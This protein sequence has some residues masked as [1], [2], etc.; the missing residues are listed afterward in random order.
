M[1][2][3]F[4]YDNIYVIESLDSDETQTGSILYNDILKW[5]AIKIGYL[6]CHL[7][8]IDTA[9][10]FFNELEIIKRN[11]QEN[12]TS[13]FLHLE[14]H[15]CTDGLIL[16]SG[17]KINWSELADRFREINIITKNNLFVSLA[18]CYG[19]YIYGKIRPT[20]PAPFFA[21]IGPWEEVKVQDIL[22][23]FATFFEYLL[24][25]DSAQHVDMVEA[26]KRLNESDKLPFRYYLYGAEEV[27]EKVFEDYERKFTN[28]DYF[29]K[30]V[31]DLVAKSLSDIR[32]RNTQT[33]PEIR[34]RIEN[35]LVAKRKQMKESIKKKFLMKNS[36]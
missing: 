26:L 28:P 14:I 34:L 35:H 29:N 23:S 5:K 20:L 16:N 25:V 8:R 7:L 21:F 15:G 24:D 31:N 22:K 17:E 9:E 18:T 10:S 3:K 30:K 6:K 11:A 27:F 32:I 36:Y 12:N 13:P 33:I 19:A 1:I 2:R 4:E